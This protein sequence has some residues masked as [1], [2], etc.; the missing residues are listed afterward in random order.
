MDSSTQRFA[1]ARNGGTDRIK[2]PVMPRHVR[3]E[4]RAA[5]VAAIA[6]LLLLSACHDS[7]IDAIYPGTLGHQPTPAYN[8]PPQ[9]KGMEYR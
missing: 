1:P 5:R 4:R 7:A 8:L 3:R 2:P 9:D 6:A